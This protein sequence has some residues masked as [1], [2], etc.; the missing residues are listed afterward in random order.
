MYNST[1]VWHH[2]KQNCGPKT[3]FQQDASSNCF[4]NALSHA[5]NAHRDRALAMHWPRQASN[6]CTWYTWYTFFLRA[7][8]CF[9]MLSVQKS[10]LIEGQNKLPERVLLKYVTHPSSDQTIIWRNPLNAGVNGC[11][12]A[13][14]LCTRGTH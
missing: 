10:T 1:C 9:I 2:K 8:M 5:D 7:L 13:G 12:A 3:C 4:Q 6:L 14:R 11:A